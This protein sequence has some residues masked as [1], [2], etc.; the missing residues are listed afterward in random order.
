[1][2]GARARYINGAIAFFSA[3]ICLT[4]IVANLNAWSLSAA[5][6]FIAF[7]LA[8]AFLASFLHR[9]R[10]VLSVVI[11][12]AVAGLLTILLIIVATK[13]I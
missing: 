1:M 11:G 5:Y 12:F 4:L 13:N 7:A 9:F 8:P 6:P 3:L 10:P 2:K